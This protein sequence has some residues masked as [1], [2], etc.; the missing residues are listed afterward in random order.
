ML[1]VFMLSFSFSFYFFCLPLPPLLLSI[2]YDVLLNFNLFAFI[3]F[4]FLIKIKIINDETCIKLHSAHS[5][6]F[7][8]DKMIDESSVKKKFA[9][10][11]KNNVFLSPVL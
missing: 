6:S 2:V 5:A 10:Y 9:K 11:V 8:N 7:V 4:F 1:S 3:R